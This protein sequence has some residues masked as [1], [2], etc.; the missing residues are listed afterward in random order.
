M[1]GGWLLGL[2]LA[3]FQAAAMPVC[4]PTSPEGNRIDLEELRAGKV[5]YL[6]FWA[7]W[8]ASCAKSFPFLNA[9]AEELGDRGVV[10]AVNL[11]E[12][13]ADARA[14]LARHPVR[15]P[16]L[17]DPGAQCAR[18]FA[19]E[20]MPATYLIDRL[21]QVRYRHLGFRPGEA[22]ALRAKALELADA[23]R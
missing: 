17:F 10:V 20:G 18:A 2:A 5:L 19:V 15:F 3:V 22:R 9:L 8:C 23:P 1:K 4:Q 12:N 21:G 11:D 14:F 6:D 7:S 16:V 13:P